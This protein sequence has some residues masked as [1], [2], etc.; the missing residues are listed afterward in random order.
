MQNG[1]N[2]IGLGEI[3]TQGVGM[4]L[5]V[6]SKKLCLHI[7]IEQLNT[8]LLESS[9]FLLVLILNWLVASLKESHQVLKTLIQHYFIQAEDF[10]ELDITELSLTAYPSESLYSIHTII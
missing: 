8:L 3:F 9:T 5:I 4:G 1:L 2:A 10:P 7:A 6:Q